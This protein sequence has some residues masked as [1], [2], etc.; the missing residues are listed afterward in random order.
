MNPRDIL[1]RMRQNLA[2]LGNG[3]KQ[4]Q[5]EL[6]AGALRS[7]LR[8][9]ARA[10]SGTWTLAARAATV[11]QLKAAIFELT[12][13]MGARLRGDLSS[14][15]ATSHQDAADFLRTADKAYAGAVR[16][17]RF[18]AGAFLEDHLRLAGQA[19]VA[20][21]AR[22]FARYG[23]ELTRAVE[24]AA[25]QAALLGRPYHDV[26]DALGGR[27]RAEVGAKDWQVRRLVETEVSAAYNQMQLDAL[28]AEDDDPADPMFKQLLAVFDSR[29][30]R[31]SVL[32]HGQKRPVREP[33]YDSYLGRYFMAPPNR[34]HDRELMHGVRPSWQVYDLGVD[35]EADHAPAARPMEIA[36]QPGIAKPRP[37][38]ATRRGP[39]PQPPGRG[40]RLA[41]NLRA[42]DVL[43]SRG[44]PRIVDVEE[45]GGRVTART[46]S[47]LLLYFAAGAAIGVLL[48]S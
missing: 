36:A 19:R 7:E 27:L 15:M 38:P 35:V 21:Y 20:N 28:V 3:A 13:A 46:E 45:R 11:I 37:P 30:G 1:R 10:R 48:S 9:L 39:P 33:F 17:L 22:S 24:V 40:Q 4:R 41:R 8:R 23:V 5:V 25:A 26:V 44:R 32:L 42:G 43:S 31:D 18:E 29:T 47:G 14:A 16:P 6:V 12:G 34:P 2:N